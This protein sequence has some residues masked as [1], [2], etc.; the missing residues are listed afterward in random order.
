MRGPD[1]TLPG[2]P[3]STIPFP[4]P[5]RRVEL[6]HY[7]LAPRGGTESL[8]DKYGHQAEELFLAF[9]QRANGYAAQ[10]RFDLAEYYLSYASFWREVADDRKIAEALVAGG[11]GN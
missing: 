6:N 4:P 2:D 1:A 9:T 8:V 5:R 7:T 11:W 10:G 3:D